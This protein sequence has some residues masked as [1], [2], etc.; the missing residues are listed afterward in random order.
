M[1]PKPPAPVCAICRGRA[2]VG[3]VGGGISLL[4]LG[5]CALDCLGWD[6]A[7]KRLAESWQGCKPF[8]N[9]EKK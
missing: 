6:L 8:E 2:F 1:K 5:L 3:T 4:N 9:L 7:E